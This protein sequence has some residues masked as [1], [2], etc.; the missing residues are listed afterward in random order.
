M[1]KYQLLFIPALFAVVTINVINKEIYISITSTR[2]TN[3]N[4]DD[5]L[6]WSEFYLPNYEKYSV[7][8]ENFCE[9]SVWERVIFAIT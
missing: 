6:L 8:L 5:I 7:K 9:R 1:I 4:E 2:T 3:V